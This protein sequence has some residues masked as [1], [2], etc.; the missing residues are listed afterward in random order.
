MKSIWDKDVPVEES[1]YNWK[2]EP[3]LFKNKL[4]DNSL[5]VVDLFS[6]SGGASLGFSMAGFN[7][8]LGID[9]H[10]PSMQTFLFNHPHACGILGEISKVNEDIVTECIGNLKTKILIAGVPCQ[11]FSL[12][13]RKRNPKD[14]RNYLFYDFIRF[15][16]ML[17]PDI[18][19]LE[20]VSGMKSI[21]NGTFVF[22]IE[23]QIKNAGKEIN[24][25]Y[26]VE[27]NILNAADFG[28]PQVRKRLIFL[29]ASEDYKII[30]PD[31]EF[32]TNNKPLRNV[33]DAFSDLPHLALG[34]SADLYSNPPELEYQKLMR[35]NSTILFN[36][37]APKHPDSTV[38]KIESTSPG[39]PMY[40][41]FTQRIRLSWDNPSPTQV[42]GGIRPQFQ[43]G[44][45]QDPRGLSVRER[46]RIQSFPD[47]FKFF[48]GIVQ[49]RVQTGNAVPPLLAKAI[50]IKIR[51]SINEIER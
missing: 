17:E 15:I 23:N 40:S 7:V 6:G 26:K 34:E 2:G 4:K 29:A 12:S 42:A 41:K 16:K 18:L 44:H 48:G 9:F 38:K 8:V 51:K 14:P 43:F 33:K 31:P 20:N 32:G 39:K 5:T 22:D 47:Y 35:Q 46:A 28:V 11:G 50:A 13:N 49:S 3:K 30:W 19:M 27:Y 24:R 36:H 10:E 25:N 37:E 45:P 1:H 21:A